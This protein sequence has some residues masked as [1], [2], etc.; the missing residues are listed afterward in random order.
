MATKKKA[1]P[2]KT[3]TR[4]QYLVVTYD[5]ADEVKNATDAADHA[6]EALGN[7]YVD[8]IFDSLAD[9]EMAA[10]DHIADGMG[11]CVIHEITITPKVRMLRGVEK[12]SM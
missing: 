6:F 10:E 9:A 3:V 2:K 12:K 4:K 7:G 8:E 5:F 1:A 11:E